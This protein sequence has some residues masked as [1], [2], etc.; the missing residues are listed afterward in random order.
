MDGQTDGAI[1]ICH[2]KFLRG[3]KK[4]L[5]YHFLSCIYIYI[6][7]QKMFHSSDHEKRARERDAVH[8]SVQRDQKWK[9]KDKS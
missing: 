3:H 1:L 9:T 7:I 2:P 6:K 8:P 5:K 4:I